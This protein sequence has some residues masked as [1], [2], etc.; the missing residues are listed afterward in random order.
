M[1]YKLANT[2][3][4]GKEEILIVL[5]SGARFVVFKY[6]ISFIFIRFERWSPA[7]LIK[8]SEEMKRY[9]K[10]YNTLNYFFASWHFPKG[11][12]LLYSSLKF[13]NQGGLDVTQD[14]VLNLDHYNQV[15]QTIS[16]ERI[17]T[18]FD[19]IST[20][21]MKELQKA[22]QL[23]FENYPMIRELYVGQYV[24]IDEYEEPPF[25]VA[26]D[27][28]DLDREALKK[29]IYTRFRKHVVFQFFSREEEP[30]L[31]EAIK[32]QGQKITGA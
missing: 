28:S 26:F 1:I 31:F 4:L 23:F 7:I 29:A 25:C 8:N 32:E 17:H 19:V 12:Y 22:L 5:N 13:N 18:L 16:I 6:N 24:N 9:Q 15:S 10:K 21:D 20:S 11:P 14:I 2:S 3:D 30:E 27:K